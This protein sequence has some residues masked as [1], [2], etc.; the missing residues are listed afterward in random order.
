M[1]RVI[2]VLM[3]LAGMGHLTLLWPPLASY[4]APFN[5]ALAAPGE[6]SPVLWLLVVGVNAER[7]KEQ[8]G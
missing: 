1:P 8:A 6:L 4:V 5:L 7:W 3:A 2:G